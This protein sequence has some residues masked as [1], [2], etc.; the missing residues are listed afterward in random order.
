MS[1]SFDNPL[2]SLFS[3]NDLLLFSPIIVKMS[4]AS[5]QGSRNSAVSS[6]LYFKSIIIALK[7][8]IYRLNSKHSRDETMMEPFPGREDEDQRQG[9]TI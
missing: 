4:R 8:D 1:K 5:A 7:G 9:Q 6:S 3:M 2:E